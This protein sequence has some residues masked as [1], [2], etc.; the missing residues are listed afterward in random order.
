MNI[1]FRNE[2]NFE[3]VY[4]SAPFSELIRLALALAAALRHPFLIIKRRAGARRAKSQAAV[5]VR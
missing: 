2:P 3:E 4:P 1:D 5:R